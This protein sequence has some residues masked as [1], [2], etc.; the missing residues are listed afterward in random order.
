MSY[1][2]NSANPVQRLMESHPEKIWSL[3][4]VSQSSEPKNNNHEMFLSALPVQVSATLVARNTST[5]R[6]NIFLIE[7]KNQILFIKS[8][9]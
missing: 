6:D 9:M 2:L 7:I 5:H 4:S 3:T 8:Q 1:G